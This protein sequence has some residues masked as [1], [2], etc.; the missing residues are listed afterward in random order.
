MTEPAGAAGKVA[1]GTLWAGG[2]AAAVVAALVAVVG[3]LFCRGILDIPLLAPEGNGV[4]GDADTA[5]YAF[6]AALAALLATGLM[7]LL[8]LA[9]PRPGTFFTWIMVL[10]TAVAVLVPFTLSASRESQLATAAINLLIGVA[11]GTLVSASARSAV[12]AAASPARP[13]SPPL[14]PPYRRP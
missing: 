11:I 14:P 4:W 12:Q 1:V 3:T 6:G 9:T 8:L 5:T 2:A 7:H 10:A 13:T